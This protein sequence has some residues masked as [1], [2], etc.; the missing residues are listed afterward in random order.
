MKKYDSLKQKALTLRKEGKSLQEI[1]DLLAVSKG[2]VYYWIKDVPLNR[3]RLAPNISKMVR[4]NK[5]RWNKLQQKAYDDGVQLYE[6]HKTDK[7][8]NHFIMLFMTEGYRKSKNTV[9]IVNSSA[10][11]IKICSH[12][13]GKFSWNVRFKLF[14]HADRD[15]RK[16][17][18]FWA[19]ELGITPDSIKL[20]L[21][22]GNGLKGRSAACEY[23][24]MHVYVND[25]TARHMLRAWVDLLTAE[26][27]SI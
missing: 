12:V 16:V 21:K 19:S 1:V 4:A 6:L 7:M 13:M 11:L 25:Y 2:T 20:Q 3:Q 15:L 27:N 10:T 18:A 24:I 26:I 22:N 14:Y 17:T 5:N 23:G 9:E 8:F